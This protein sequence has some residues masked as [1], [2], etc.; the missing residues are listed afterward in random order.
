LSLCLS[1]YQ[2]MKNYPLLN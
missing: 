2:A 1:K